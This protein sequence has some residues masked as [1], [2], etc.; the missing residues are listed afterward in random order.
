MSLHEP[1]E[2]SLPAIAGGTPLRAADYPRWPQ[3][4]AGAAE[5]LLEVLESGNWD[6][7]HGRFVRSF[8]ER[9]AAYQE[10]EHG[11]CV[12]NGEVGLRVALEALEIGAGDEV[13][14]PAYTFVASATA[15]VYAGGVPVFA[16]VDPDTY[17]LS[18]TAAEELISERTVALMPVHIAGLPSDMSRLS[19]LA[20]RH[21]L[22]VIEDA[23]QGWGARCDGRAVGAQGDVGMFSFQASKNL[24]CGEGGIILTNDAELASACRSIA[25]NGRGASADRYSHV[26]LGTNSRLTD[27]QGALLC[28]G[29]DGYPE[30]LKRR[31]RNAAAL[32]AALGEIDGVEAQALPGA[33]DQS[34]WHLFV[35]RIAP[36]AFGAWTKFD[37]VRA[38]VAEG[39]PATAGYDVPACD[40]AVFADSDCAPEHRR[41]ECPVAERACASEAVWIRQNALL[42]GREDALD[43]ARALDKLQRFSL[44]KVG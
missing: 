2:L 4:P 22:K 10:A 41:G 28:C 19:A 13:I 23:A 14:V 16:D 31:S 26:R 6:S 30:E 36:R 25:D 12:A 27:F 29:L 24:A 7:R 11:I 42:G 3:P 15:V 39:V 32:R 9:F 37:L 43:V 1:G 8:E 33:V 38:L 40:Q 44:S 20:K 35:L 18:A 21:G 34:A 17:C 5:A